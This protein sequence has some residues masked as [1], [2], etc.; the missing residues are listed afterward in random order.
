MSDRVSESDGG[1]AVGKQER[2][3]KSKIF[4]FERGSIHYSNIEQTVASGQKDSPLAV[5]N[6]L[7][8]QDEDKLIKVTEIVLEDKILRIRD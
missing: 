2:L 5:H 4:R 7:C 8:Y 3:E 6:Y 1:E